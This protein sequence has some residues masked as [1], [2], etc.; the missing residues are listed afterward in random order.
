MNRIHLFEFEDFEWFPSFIRNY[1]TDY[2]QFFISKTRM[3]EPFVP[4]LVKALEDSKSHHIIDLGSGGGGGLLF[5]NQE[6]LKSIPDLQI[7]L[8]DYFPN[9]PA[10]EEAKKTAS[11]INY[12]QESVDAKKIPKELKGFRTQF[13]SFHHFQPKEAQQILQNAIDANTSIGI[14]EAQERSLISFLSI[15]GLPLIVLLTTPFIRP[16][17]FGRLLFT[18]LIPIVPLFILW[19]GIASIFRT[20]SKKEMQELINGLNGQ[21]QFDWEIGK[22]KSNLGVL[23]YLIGIKKR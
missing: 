13:L 12:I 6:L 1:G 21:E 9:L 18:Y 4:L 17:S 8:T 22:L 11:N 5:L 23:P 14:F 15:L 3:Y 10:F 7:T 19:D 20:Y 16:F 2:L